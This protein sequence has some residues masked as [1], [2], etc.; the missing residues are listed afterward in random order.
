MNCF[1]CGSELREQKV[2]CPDDNP[3]CA[4]LH[5]K[6]I[7]PMCDKSKDRPEDQPMPTVSEKSR[8][9]Q[10]SLI[11]MVRERRQLGIQRYGSPLM[12]HN[13]RNALQ[14]ALE[15]AVDLSAYLMQLRMEADDAVKKSI[16]YQYLL[17]YVSE[18]FR[19]AK[20]KEGVFLFCKEHGRFAE[21]NAVVPVP[22]ETEMMK[23]IGLH[24]DL[25]DHDEWKA[26]HKQ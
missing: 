7:C 26:Y 9:V 6:T 22:G 4:I 21:Y 19:V 11:E 18:N 3:E 14:D 13:G 5:L 24:M 25:H 23:Q 20:E 2:P 15:E 10:G 16:S 17:T 1:K 12:T 8:D